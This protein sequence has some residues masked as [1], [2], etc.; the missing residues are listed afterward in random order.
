MKKLFK[1][2]IGKLSSKRFSVETVK[3]LVAFRN[4]FKMSCEKK[5]G[6]EGVARFST[7]WKDKRN[8]EAL[9]IVLFEIFRNHENKDIRFGADII[10]GFFKQCFQEMELKEKL[11]KKV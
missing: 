3:K 6:D 10:V 7:F 2:L 8:Q 5:I 1:K 11:E 9:E 4:V